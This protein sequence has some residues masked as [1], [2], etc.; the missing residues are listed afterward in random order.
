MKKPQTIVTFYFFGKKLKLS[1]LQ[2]DAVKDLMQRF[3]GDQAAMKRQVLSASSVEQNFLGLKRLIVSSRSHLFLHGALHTIFDS[4]KHRQTCFLYYGWDTLH[5][6]KW[7][8]EVSGI[9]SGASLSV[10]VHRIHFFWS[11]MTVQT[12]QMCSNSQQLVLISPGLE[13]GTKIR[14]KTLHCNVF[15]P[16]VGKLAVFLWD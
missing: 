8:L 1:D 14:P 5:I 10:L 9:Y 11:F 3:L 4:F 16:F 6:S 13:I 12:L 7:E 2:G 15:Q